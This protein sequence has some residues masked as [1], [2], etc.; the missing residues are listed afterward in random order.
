M[1]RAV[2]V[3]AALYR[4]D[5]G[6]RA[7]R[8][9]GMATGARSVAPASLPQAALDAAARFGQEPWQDQGGPR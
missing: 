1:P 3:A 5:L 2:Q 6:F 7:A 4:D 8:A 9:A